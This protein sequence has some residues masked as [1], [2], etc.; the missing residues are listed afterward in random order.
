[1]LVGY[2]TD[3]GR[4]SAARISYQAIST[5]PM[6]NQSR[7]SH[8]LAQSGDVAGRF[9]DAFTAVMMLVELVAEDFEHGHEGEGGGGG[10]HCVCVVRAFDAGHDFIGCVV[11]RV[12][13]R[14]RE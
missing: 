14:G 1:M 10:V 4:T 5:P 7:S 13:S 6:S 3:W 8:L 12:G 2:K 9:D 11:L